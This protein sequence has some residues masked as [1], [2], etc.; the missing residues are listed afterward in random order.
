[1]VVEVGATGEVNGIGNLC[2]GTLRLDSTAVFT[3][4][5]NFE[6]LDEKGLFPAFNLDR[7]FSGTVPWWENLEPV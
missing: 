3:L 4:S 1:M 7:E 6:G 2:Q 5:M